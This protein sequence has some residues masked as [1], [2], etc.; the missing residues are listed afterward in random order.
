MDSKLSQQLQNLNLTANECPHDNDTWQAFLQAIDNNFQENNKEVNQLKKILMDLPQA[1]CIFNPQGQLL[2]FNTLA[3]KSVPQLRTNARCDL[4]FFQLRHP[5]S[6]QILNKNNIL[7]YMQ[8]GE[9]LHDNAAFIKNSAQVLPIA[10]TISPIQV[11]KKP[12]AFMILFSDASERQQEKKDLIAAKEA[13]EKASLAKSSFLSSMS[14]ELRTPMNAI[15]GYCELLQEDLTDFGTD[16][17]DDARKVVNELQNYARYINQAG[18]HLME[19]INEV[20]DL[21][22]IEAGK[23][24][25]N[26]DNIDLNTVLREV[27]IEIHPQLEPLSLILDNQIAAK[28]RLSVLADRVCLKKILSNLLSNAAKYNREHGNITLTARYVSKQRLRLTV[29]DTGIGMEPL[30][31]DSIFKPFTRLSGLNLIEGTGI[32]LTLT[33]QLVELMDGDM[34]VETVL[35]QGSEFWVDLPTGE[36]LND[37]RNVFSNPRR[38]LLLYI[39]DSRTNVSLVSKILRARPDMALISA[40]TGEMGF[41]LAQKHRPDVIL[42]DINL[43]GIDGFEVLNRLRSQDKTA[44]IP[45]L[46]LSADDTQEALSQ[47]RQAGFV[48]YMIKPLQKKTFLQHINQLLPLHPL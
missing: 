5:Q 23:I 32:G 15:L 12:S 10:C 22:R 19:L 47:A 9:T 13:A 8:Q 45:V 4:D 26:I 37:P 40:P 33:K 27:L 20:L 7:A 6:K 17:D 29:S 42:L 43:P 39:E 11:Q 14:H 38:H 44:H 18:T 35:S 3:K 24:N 30:L 46:G 16:C 31:V 36:V 34:G 48:Q 25:I 41:E 28:Q 21:T 2:F 1:L